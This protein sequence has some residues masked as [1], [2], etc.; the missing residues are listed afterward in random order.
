[1][2]PSRHI[3]G[4]PLN[5]NS[6]SVTLHRK[7]QIAKLTELDAVSIISTQPF[8]L[9][10]IAGSVSEDKQQMLW[11]MVETCTSELTSEEWEELFELLLSYSD[12]VG[13]EL[14]RMH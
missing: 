2:S 14:Y 4:T 7:T 1:M 5:H 13:D 3:S 9:G 8:K 6:E 11:G 10:G 12:G